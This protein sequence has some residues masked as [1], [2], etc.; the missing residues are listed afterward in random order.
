[1]LFLGSHLSVQELK[2]AEVAVIKDVQKRHFVVEI[3]AIKKHGIHVAHR[4]F[5]RSSASQV[6]YLNPVV[7]GDSLLRVVGHLWKSTLEDD[8]KYPIILPSRDPVVDWIVWSAHKEDAH[9]G[10]E[11]THARL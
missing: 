9:Q 2:E 6:K 3:K 10:L 7:H 5:N 4:K 8:V 1:M 11:Y